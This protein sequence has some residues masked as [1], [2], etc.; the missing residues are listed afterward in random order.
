MSCQKSFHIAV[1]FKSVAARI[2][3]EWET[4]DNDSTTDV[5]RALTST[6]YVASL[7]ILTPRKLSLDQVPYL[8]EF[9]LLVIH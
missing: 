4:D 5:L 6:K 9:T 8:G 3:L 2:F 7:G 1:I